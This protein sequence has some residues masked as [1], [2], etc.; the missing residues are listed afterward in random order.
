MTSNH[1]K[2]SQQIQLQES[3]NTSKLLQL[4][5]FHASNITY[6]GLFLRCHGDEKVIIDN[7]QPFSLRYNREHSTEV[8]N[9][10]GMRFVISFSECTGYR[11][12]HEPIRRRNISSI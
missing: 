9:R 1:D 11:K 6:L 5:T 12:R 10:V 2:L 7:T 8:P 4:K 3:A